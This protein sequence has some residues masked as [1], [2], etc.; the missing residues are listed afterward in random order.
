MQK[1]ATLDVAIAIVGN[2]EIAKRSPPFGSTAMSHFMSPLSLMAINQVVT[3]LIGFLNNPLWSNPSGNSR[4]EI[5]M[6]QIPML[7]MQVGNMHSNP[8]VALLSSAQPFTVMYSNMRLS[9][10]VGDDDS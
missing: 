8:I 2:W 7:A 3:Q 1:P 6:T 5:P 9:K 4:M 10:A